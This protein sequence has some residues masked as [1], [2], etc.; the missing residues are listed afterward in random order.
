MVVEWNLDSRKWPPAARRAAIS[1]GAATMRLH[2]GQFFGN[3]RR[4]SMALNTVSLPPAG[5]AA[6]CTADGLRTWRPAFDSLQVQHLRGCIVLTLSAPA[7]AAPVLFELST[8]AR[9]HLVRL[10]LGAEG[11]P[12]EQ[13]AR[14]AA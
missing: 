3:P 10:L 13:E 6:H 11:A 2:A 12:A 8:A 4:F 9:D 7:L 5:N 14:D 1:S